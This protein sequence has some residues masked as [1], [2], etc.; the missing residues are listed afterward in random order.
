MAIS[1]LLG[2]CTPASSPPLDGHPARKPV[3]RTAISI[4]RSAPC[5]MAL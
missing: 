4:A 1:M 3:R 5:I 2:T